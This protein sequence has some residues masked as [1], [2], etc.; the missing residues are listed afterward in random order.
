MSEFSDLMTLYVKSKD[1][2]TYTMAQYCDLDRSTMYKIINGKR[3][4]SSES[5]VCKISEFMRLSPL[6][7]SELIEAYRM[8]LIGYEVYYR[9]KTVCDFFS[10]FS[11]SFNDFPELSMSQSQFSMPASVMPLEGRSV[12]DHAIYNTVMLEAQKSSGHL[13]LLLQPDDH[14]I[15]KLLT[16]VSKEKAS[17][18]IDHI[19]CLNN[20]ETITASKKNYNLLCLKN[21]M[22]LYICSH[23]YNSYYYYENIISHSSIFNFLPYLIL[24]SDYAIALS[25]DMEMGV[26][27]YDK[28][29]IGFFNRLYKKY[30]SHTSLIGERIG[31]IVPDFKYFEYTKIGQTPGVSFQTEPCL[32]PMFNK[33]IINK[34]LRKTFTNT[35][36]FVDNFMEHIQ[37]VMSLIKN[38]KTTYIFTID[39][40]ISFLET[41]RLS[42]FPVE[43][44]DPLSLDDR[45][46][47]INKLVTVCK[48]YSYKILKQNFGNPRSRLCV[49]A[50]P[51]HSYLLFPSVNNDLIYLDLEE[52]SILNAF[53]DYLTNLREDAFYT[54][55]ESIEV[56][57]RLIKKYRQDKMVI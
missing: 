13:K 25:A 21:I 49:Y 17:L 30:L 26:I 8:T 12:I 44:Y 50:N 48:N 19:L 36:Q 27:Y 41:G 5:L 40:V 43:M 23:N 57:E 3:N 52:P 18:K 34:Y 28:S 39:G 51:Q 35:G 24:T 16:F 54:K 46:Y 55:A 9:R 4:P 47:L 22:P 15:M 6:E 20:M 31:S 38:N 45:I 11:N 33:N 29:M 10:S 32:V 37:K 7:H 53:Y 2:K 56:L 1:I 42:E 14:F